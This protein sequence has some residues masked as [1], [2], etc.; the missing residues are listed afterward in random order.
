[1]PGRVRTR[2]TVVEYKLVNLGVDYPVVIMH[3][4]DEGLNEVRTVNTSVYY[5]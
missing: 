1:M 2:D 5:D 4:M 3:L